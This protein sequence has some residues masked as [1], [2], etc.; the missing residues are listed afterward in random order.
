MNARQAAGLCRWCGVPVVPGHT[1][2]PAHY[3]KQNEYRKNVR[4]RKVKNRV[5]VA[6]GC[7]NPRPAG[8]KQCE[9]CRARARAYH[10]GAQR[11]K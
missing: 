8:F 5:C 4:D 7:P 6:G 10:A 1:L 3:A 11:G 9:E 2:C